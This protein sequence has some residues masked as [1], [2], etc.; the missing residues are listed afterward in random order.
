MRKL[1]TEEMKNVNG[2]GIYHWYCYNSRFQSPYCYETYKNANL[3]RGVHM[4]KYAESEEAV[5][6]IICPKNH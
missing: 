2:G 1:S 3:N 4:G 5:G 6:I